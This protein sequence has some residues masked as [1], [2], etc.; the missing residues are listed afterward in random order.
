LEPGRWADVVHLRVDDTAFVGLADD[1]AL[2][3]NL[4]WAGGG[5]LV[6]DVWVAGEQMLKDGVSTRVD[7]AAALTAARAVARR[8]AKG[9]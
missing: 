5:R 8:V 2:L 1:A 4:V 3:S 7:R 6:R 9:Q